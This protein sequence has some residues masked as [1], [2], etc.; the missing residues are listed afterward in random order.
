MASKFRTWRNAL[1]ALIVISSIGILLYS[2]LRSKTSTIWGN[3]E[4]NVR[5]G[6]TTTI[7]DGGQAVAIIL[8]SSSVDELVKL[9]PIRDATSCLEIAMEPVMRF[10]ACAD[11][12]IGVSGSIHPIS[13]EADMALFERASADLAAHIGAGNAVVEESSQLVKQLLSES[14]YV[15]SAVRKFK[16]S[17]VD[18]YGFTFQKGELGVSHIELV[19]RCITPNGPGF[20]WGSYSDISRLENFFLNR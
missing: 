1:L 10:L 16:H 20:I 8:E 6:E 14:W 15:Y 19:G 12:D 18:C 5:D 11:G 9:P 17:D 13:T 7:L 4:V 2:G 3:V